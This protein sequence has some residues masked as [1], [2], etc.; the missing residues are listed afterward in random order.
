[1]PSSDATQCGLVQSWMDFGVSPATPPAA[2]ASSLK[3]L[4][5][6]HCRSMVLRKRLKARGL[7][8]RATSTSGAYFLAQAIPRALALWPFILL[9]IHSRSKGSTVYDALGISKGTWKILWKKALTLAGSSMPMSSF[10]PSRTT[11]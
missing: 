11:S 9:C 3:A 4:S 6:A 8:P 10:T 2:P 1:M 5:T 7:V